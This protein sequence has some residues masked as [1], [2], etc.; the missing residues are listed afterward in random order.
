MNVCKR[1]KARQIRETAD[2]DRPISL[3]IDR[4]EEGV[5]FFGVAR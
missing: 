4:V 2:R 3:A 5:A 1:P